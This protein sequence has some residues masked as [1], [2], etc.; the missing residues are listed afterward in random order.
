MSFEFVAGNLALDFVATVS[1]RTTTRLERLQTGADLADWIVHAHLLDT[2]P[3]VSG[4]ELAAAK[5]L[6]EAMFRLVTALTVQAPLSD[7][8]RSQVNDAASEAPPIV[9]L[10]A[11]GQVR[12]RGD[13]AAVLTLLAR[14]CIELFDDAERN[15]IRW[16]A[17]AQ[18]TRVFID[19][20][21]GHRRRWC[22]MAGCGDRAKAAA[23][24]Q[25]H[26]RQDR[27]TP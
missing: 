11:D 9:S 23:Y 22:G 27:S 24:R 13:V 8:D 25:R 15:L 14:A 5:E 2:P 21:R 10:T 20:S 12:R 16:C 26:R 17:D 18:C 6:R 7:A 1:E 4:R 19:R 3:T